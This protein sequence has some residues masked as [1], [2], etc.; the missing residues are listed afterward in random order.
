MFRYFLRFGNLLR[1]DRLKAYL[2]SVMELTII[3]YSDS[4]LKYIK[5]CFPLYHQT[6]LFL[7]YMVM[8]EQRTVKMK[9]AQIIDKV[10]ITHVNLER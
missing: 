1:I 8:Y 10:I 5:L 2:D 4:Q 9:I 3:I 6:S 7:W